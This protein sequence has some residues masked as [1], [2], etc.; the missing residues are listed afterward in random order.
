VQ[1]CQ[2]QGMLILALPL[3]SENPAAG[4]SSTS[5][6]QSANTALAQGLAQGFQNTQACAGDGAGIDPALIQLLLQN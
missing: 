5:G 4:G 1:S 6:G 2:V 3:L